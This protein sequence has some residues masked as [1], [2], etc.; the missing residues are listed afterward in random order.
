[1][2]EIAS[3]V[4]RYGRQSDPLD[5]LRTLATVQ[6]LVGPA[7]AAEVDAARAHG[8]SWESVCAALGMPRSTLA[9]Q[10]R[11]GSITVPVRRAEDEETDHGERAT[12]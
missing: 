9:R 4:P 1:M 7:L 12:G 10:H 5:R 2:T 11:S 8:S 6:R 3:L